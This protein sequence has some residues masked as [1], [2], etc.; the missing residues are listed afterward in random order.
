MYTASVNVLFA[1]SGR[2]DHSVL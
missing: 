1:L 2:L